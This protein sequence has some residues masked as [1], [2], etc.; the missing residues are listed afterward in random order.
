MYSYSLIRWLNS[1]NFLLIASLSC[2][3][4]YICYL[5]LENCSAW[6]ESFEILD[7]YWK[8]FSVIS[9]ISLIRVSRLVVLRLKFSMSY[10]S[11]WITCYFSFDSATFDLATIYNLSLSWLNKAK[12]FSYSAIFLFEFYKSF[13]LLANSCDLLSNYYLWVNSTSYFFLN[14]WTYAVILWKFNSISWKLDC[15]ELSS[16]FLSLKTLLRR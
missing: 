13:T 5:S 2:P 9:S 12:A 8:I 15:V 1:L 3:N 16:L 11:C 6:L 14:C 7:S 4:C 10:W